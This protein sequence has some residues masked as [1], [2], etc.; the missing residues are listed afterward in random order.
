MP[1]RIETFRNDIGGSA[2][3]KALS[4]PL[5]A[6]AAHALVAKVAAT[7]PV[8][9]YDPDSIA[10]AF[11]CFYH[12]A[13]AEPAYYFVQKIED[14]QRRFAD[15]SAQP[16]TDI[17][18]AKAGAVFVASFEPERKLLPI[19]HLLPKG[20]ETFSLESLKLPAELQT[21]RARYLSPL[22]F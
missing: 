11:D 22:N 18:D 12:L 10:P 13:Q 20:I 19:R 1:L 4:H 3:Y 14:L 5:A 7:G 21:D 8:A 6:P 15:L 2:F 9:I 17:V 16:I